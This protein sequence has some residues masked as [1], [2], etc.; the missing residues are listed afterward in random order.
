VK[1]DIFDIQLMDHPVSREGEGQDDPNIDE[2]D[3]GAEGLV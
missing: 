1:K 2:L 3:D